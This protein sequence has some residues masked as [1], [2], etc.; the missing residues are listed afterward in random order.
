MV[1][2]KKSSPRKR[3]FSPQSDYY[4]EEPLVKSPVRKGRRSVPRPLD[5]EAEKADTAETAVAN[6]LPTVE[7]NSGDELPDTGNELSQVTPFI[8]S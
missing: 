6:I 1:S 4:S 7:D 3:L 8:P 2:G 5:K